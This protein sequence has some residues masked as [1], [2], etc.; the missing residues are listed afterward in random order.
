MC[1]PLRAAALDDEY[2]KPN[3]TPPKSDKIRPNMAKAD[4]KL[5]RYRATWNRALIFPLAG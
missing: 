5:G 3:P 2:I 4:A 1:P